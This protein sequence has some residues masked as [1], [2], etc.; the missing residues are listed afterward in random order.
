[1]EFFRARHMHCYDFHDTFTI[2][3]SPYQ[4][5]IP[6]MAY[7][8]DIDK[9]RPD[10]LP[11]DVFCHRCAVLTLI[12]Y[13]PW[14]SQH[15]RCSLHPRLNSFRRYA[16]LSRPYR[17]PILLLLS[18]GCALF[19]CL[20]TATKS[21]ALRAENAAGGTQRNATAGRRRHTVTPFG[22]KCRGLH[23]RA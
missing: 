3:A 16:A 9:Q 17:A 20:P 22:R 21:H 15:R 6:S 8:R 13:L 18:V 4:I 11:T 10:F 19:E 7:E 12:S 23:P 2:V 1:M 5:M 14:V